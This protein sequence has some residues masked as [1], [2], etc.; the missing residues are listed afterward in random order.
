VTDIWVLERQHSNK[1]S[2][3]QYCNNEEIAKT[4][5]KCLKRCFPK[6]RFRISKFVRETP[7]YVEQMKLSGFIKSVEKA[8]RA[9]KRSKLRFP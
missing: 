2:V 3:E 1:W 7:I 4:L 8:Q 6:N 9:T 5:L